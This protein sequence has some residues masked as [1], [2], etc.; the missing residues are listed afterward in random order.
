MSR[1]SMSHPGEGEEGVYRVC[2]YILHLR[3]YCKYS[4]LQLYLLQAKDETKKRGR[5]RSRKR[6]EKE[7]YGNI[8]N[9][10]QQDAV[11]QE[12]GLKKF[13]TISHLLERLKEDL[14]RSQ[15]FT[16]HFLCDE[17]DGLT[18]LLDILKVIQLSQANMTSGLDHNISKAVFNKA[19]ADEHET[20]LCLKLCAAT[21]TGL[22]NIAEHPSGLFTISVCV[23]SNFSKSRVLALDILERMCQLSQ[24]HQ[25]VAD[26]ITMLRLR[27]GE[28]VRFK[29]IV[30]NF[31]IIKIITISNICLGMLLSYNNSTFQIAC[32]KFLN[33]FVETA[34]TVEEKVFLQVEL[35]EAGLSNSELDSLMLK[36]C[37]HVLY[38]MIILSCSVDK[39]MMC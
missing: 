21:D 6:D 35:L 11:S 27:F 28:P 32:L 24:G 31:Y 7:K 29:F 13:S 36:A 2:D 14:F 19:L 9:S 5:S 25:M 17:N 4:G 30:G 38:L 37:M 26:A 39:E 8:L 1:V 22:S 16:Q 3:R 20:L 33:R 18:L 23:M 15:K 10:Y 12:M 34:R